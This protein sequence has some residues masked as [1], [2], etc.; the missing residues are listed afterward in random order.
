MTMHS[1]K[2]YE[3]NLETLYR[4]KLAR[5]P[6]FDGEISLELL[7]VCCPDCGRRMIV[8]SVTYCMCWEESDSRLKEA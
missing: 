4:A 5:E 2:S 8:E 3:Q 6:F 1:P 7:P